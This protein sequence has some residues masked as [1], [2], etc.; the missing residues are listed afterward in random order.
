MRARQCGRERE[1]KTE[2]G[3]LTRHGAGTG[4]Y[5]Q[6]GVVW[7]VG[8]AL[9]ATTIYVH[10]S[11]VV[12][13]NS[14]ILRGEGGCR[15]VVRLHT[16][17]VHIPRGTGILIR[18]IDPEIEINI[19][20]IIQTL[21]LVIHILLINKNKSIF[22]IFF[23]FLQTSGLPRVRENITFSLA[24]DIFLQ[25]SITNDMRILSITP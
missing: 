13:C 2:G 21:N 1:T 7:V 17:K 23:K 19:Y 4:H 11:N 3:C 14:E 15:V 8:L 20:I 9:R 22:K 10:N 12:S 16:L 25:P 24:C 5:T 6:K 18:S